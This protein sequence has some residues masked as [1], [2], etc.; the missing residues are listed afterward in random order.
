M[1][2]MTSAPFQQCGHEACD[3]EPCT[4]YDHSY[5]YERDDVWGW[6][7]SCDKCERF[8]PGVLPQEHY[9]DQHYDGE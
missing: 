7:T 9:E 4:R 1:G 3:M 8:I 6:G 5:H 2:I